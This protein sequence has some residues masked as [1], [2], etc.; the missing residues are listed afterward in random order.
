ML[1]EIGFE[2]RGA[3]ASILAI[4]LFVLV[5][6]VGLIFKTIG[7]SY[8]QKASNNASSNND[9]D[10]ELQDDEVETDLFTGEPIEKNFDY[11]LDQKFIYKSMPVNAQEISSAKL[12]KYIENSVPNKSSLEENKLTESNTVNNNDIELVFNSL[13]DVF[14][15][16]TQLCL[17]CIKQSLKQDKAS[18]ASIVL[19]SIG[20]EVAS[21]VL[22]RL[23]AEEVQL[24]SELMLKQGGLSK[25]Q[26]FETVNYF[27]SLVNNEVSIET[28]NK[29]YIK[30]I[31]VEALD[32]EKAE[33]LLEK[34][35]YGED[36][37]VLDTL[38]WMEPE[39]VASLI[40]NQAKALKVAAL[41]VLSA[42]H[43]AK[44][45]SFYSDKDKAALLFALANNEKLD[46]GS[47]KKLA[48]LIESHLDSGKPVQKLEH[49]NYKHAA[50]IM[51]HFD[52]IAEEDIINRLNSMED[53]L[54]D[55]IVK[56]FFEFE[57]LINLSD[58]DLQSLLRDTNSKE[59]LA[60]LKGADV[61]LQEKIFNNMSKR[62]AK[63]MQED[64]NVSEAIK[65]SEVESAQ[66]KI[67]N[68]AKELADKGRIT[69]NT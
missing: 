17:N 11:V 24:I 58:K 15:S 41:S 42:E 64:L 51:Q 31:L 32:R 60:A 8:K 29:D 18:Y 67:V 65:L 39:I 36:L 25:T 61:A 62:A 33:C 49:D 7:T 48:N 5:A 28:G 53:G 54:G 35:F 21:F 50:K 14:K 47:L 38:V 63:V 23:K 66:D 37:E 1:E 10:L 55:S 13:I 20:V 30:N 26:L 19:L 3:L 45:L 44:V 27:N 57:D 46:T 2:H 59:L 12:S 56:N 69:L 4:I 9:S 43:A 34:Y 68:I 52:E 16:N 6:I 40:K 22:S